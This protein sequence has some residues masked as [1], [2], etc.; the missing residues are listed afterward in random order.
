[1][2][3]EETDAQIKQSLRRANGELFSYP[4]GRRNSL[5]V[6]I[7]EVLVPYRIPESVLVYVH[8]RINQTLIYEYKVMEQLGIPAASGNKLADILVYQPQ[9]NRLYLLYAINR[10]GPL[11]KPHKD[12]TEKLLKRCSAERIY[13]SVVYDRIDYGRYAP[14]FAWGS[15]VWMAQIPDHVVCHV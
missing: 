12:E 4:E 6:D 15:Q 11:Y 9:R 10:F 8:D 1:M 3:E 7:L 14:F 2:I 5:L 13:V